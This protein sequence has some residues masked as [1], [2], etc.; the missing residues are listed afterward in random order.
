MK[1]KLTPKEPLTLV[2]LARRVTGLTYAELLDNRPG[3]GQRTL[4]HA[5]AGDQTLRTGSALAL[6]NALGI[7]PEDGNIDRIAQIISS[8]EKV[9]W[10]ITLEIAE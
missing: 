5:E 7:A 3:F 4:Q 2:K 6:A 10:K 1:I 9:R 8:G